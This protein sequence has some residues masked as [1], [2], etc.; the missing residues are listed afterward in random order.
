MLGG[1][2]LSNTV[3]RGKPP[4]MLSA[5][6]PPSPRAQ[7]MHCRLPSLLVPLQRIL[8]S[9]NWSLAFELPRACCIYPILQWLTLP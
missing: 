6:S 3:T 8:P 7:H 5:C 2:H 4:H 9:I 1:P